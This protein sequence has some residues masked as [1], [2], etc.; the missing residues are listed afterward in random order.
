MGDPLIRTIS[1]SLGYKLA[2]RFVDKAQGVLTSMFGDVCKWRQQRAALP[3]DPYSGFR[4]QPS[5]P[6]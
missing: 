5:Q 4:L 6:P 3:G 1:L 2:G